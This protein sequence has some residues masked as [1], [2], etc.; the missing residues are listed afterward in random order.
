MRGTAVG[1]NL[2]LAQKV[3]AGIKLFAN[4]PTSDY[5]KGKYEGLDPALQRV[6]LHPYYQNAMQRGDR[7]GA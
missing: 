5:V 3:G 4:L 2:D 6:I 1:I 7:V